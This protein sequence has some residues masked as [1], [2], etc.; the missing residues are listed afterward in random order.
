MSLD[1]ARP[2]LLEPR[3]L[4][5]GAWI[6]GQ[7]RSDVTNPATGEVI[8]HAADLTAAEMRQAIDAAHD[9]GPAWAA[10]TARERADILMRWHDLMLDNQED[11]ARILTAE[12]GKPIAEARGEIAYGASFI[13][14]FAEEGR[15]V[16]G[17]IIPGHQP[18]KRIMVLKQPI[19]VV[20]SI[21]PWNFPN[22]MIARK[23]APALAAGCTFV[24]RPA[25]STPLSAT[26]MARL[27]HEA[28]LPDGVLN[29]VTG[30]DSAGLGAELCRNPK[31]RKLTFTGSTE[32]GR[33]LMRQ[34][35]QNIT[36]LSLELGGN[37]PFIVFD[38]A[39]LEAAVQG[40]IMAKYRNGGQTCVCANR[41]YVQD[42]LH[43]A[44]VERLGEA[45]AAMKVGP[46][47]D[48]TNQI[49]PLIDQPAMDK[50]QAHLDDAV[51]RGAR[52]VAGGRRSDQGPLYFEPTVLADIQPGTRLLAEETFG[53]IAP[54]VRFHSETEVIAMANATEFGLA[55]YFYTRDLGRSWRVAEALE[56]GIVGLN[57]GL[58]STAEAPFGGVKASGLGREGSRYGIDDFLE[59]KYLCAAV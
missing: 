56:Y 25:E 40:A 21:T 9:A 54:V 7:N 47:L 33:I 6:A 59:I 35:A 42:G 45:V 29:I 10:R 27:G 24:G 17:D 57:T 2:E 3:A 48:E 52:L 34:C 49:G 13:R 50:V 11:L 46:G 30:S 36:K 26:A 38:D 55:A 15:R 58:I 41:I 28:G 5:A 20:G 4:I 39:D 31:V 14:W 37:A 23:V 12:M 32:V 22:A 19:G 8:A 53:P 44:F 43:D 16:Y 18:D 51:G 1:L